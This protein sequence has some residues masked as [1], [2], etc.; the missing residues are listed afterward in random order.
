M[1]SQ[2]VSGLLGSTVRT[3]SNQLFF[4]TRLEEY[5]HAFFESSVV[6]S[7]EIYFHM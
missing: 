5:V 7:I 6:S 3:T 1:L 2:N 4:T